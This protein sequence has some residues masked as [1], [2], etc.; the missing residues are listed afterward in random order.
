[1]IFFLSI[2][3]LSSLNGSLW[4]SSVYTSPLSI[5]IIVF[6]FV[7]IAIVGR[8]LCEKLDLTLQLLLL[9]T[10]VFLQMDISDFSVSAQ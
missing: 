3:S 4:S 10:R 9:Q 2:L 7:F 8:L 5:Q 6:A 1:M